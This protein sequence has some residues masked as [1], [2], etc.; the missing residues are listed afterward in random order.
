M[1]CNF[2][3]KMPMETLQWRFHVLKV[4]LGVRQCRSYVP[5]SI[6]QLAVRTMIILIGFAL[7]LK[8]PWLCFNFV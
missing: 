7:F 3:V 6:T 4:L 2:L 8:S 1:L 5:V